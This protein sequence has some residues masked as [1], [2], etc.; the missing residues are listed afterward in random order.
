MLFEATLN[1]LVKYYELIEYTMRFTPIKYII[2]TCNKG[3]DKINQL[4]NITIKKCL[5][6]INRL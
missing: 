2:F 4:Q 5:V 3:F 1:A 6:F